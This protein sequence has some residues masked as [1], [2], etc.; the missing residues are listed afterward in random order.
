[1]LQG[2]R[3]SI[4]LAFSQILVEGS[5]FLRNLILA[6]LVGAEQMG[7]AVAMALGIRL[8][9]MIGDLG[10]ERYLV[11]AP[12]SNL[13]KVRGSVH[14]VQVVKG[15]LLT[16]V[17]SL[18]AYP[19][20]AAINPALEPSIFILASMVL[21]IRGFINTEYRER[22]REKDFTG[23]LYADGI[24]N[25]VAVIAMVP[26][27]M[28]TRD[29]SALAIASVLQATVLCLVSHLLAKRK[30]A[31]VF[32]LREL[33]TALKFGAPIAVNGLLM[34]FALQGDRL[35][36]TMNF[37]PEELARFALA[38]QL[39]LLP[40]L[41]G[42]RYLLTLDLPGFARAN[43]QSE[44]LRSRFTARLMQVAVIATLMTL[45]FTYLGGHL[46]GWLYGPAFVCAP[47]VMALLS[48][49]AALRLLRAVPNTLLLARGKTMKMLACNLPRLVALPVAFALVAG[50]SGLVS[51]VVI[52][53]LSEAISLVIGLTMAAKPL[54]HERFL[55]NRPSLETSR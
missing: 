40:A 11:Q 23:T 44:A 15:C 5:A 14:L 26:L 22:Q 54:Y 9:E 32:D 42:A 17:A 34:F 53:V 10:L 4:V 51:V 12:S 8:L 1:M 6:R 43:E 2:V 18:A 36:V 49:A 13:P 25:V 30:M 28:A 29:Y 27:A 21:I 50:G 35:V 19:L 37:P 55:L 52:G 48:L 16:G 39:T 24:S 33:Q 38:A 47:A 31:F 7:L 3:P 41:M 20:C 46:V 45:F